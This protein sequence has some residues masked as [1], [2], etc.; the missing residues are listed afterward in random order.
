MNE[1]KNH[2]AM[3]SWLDGGTIAVLLTM[4][5]S[6]LALG[7]LIHIGHSRISEDICE[8]REAI[9]DAR[10]ERQAE[11]EERRTE[12]S[13]DIRKLDDYLPFGSSGMVPIQATAAGFD[14]RPHRVAQQV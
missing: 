14:T 2:R 3:P 6:E 10:R 11:I 12:P 4:I 8:W 13:N 9:R 1:R 5:G 7:T